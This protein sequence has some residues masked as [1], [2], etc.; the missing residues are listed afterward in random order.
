MAFTVFY[1]FRD[2]DRTR[3]DV[4][5]DVLGLGVEFPSGWCVVDWNRDAFPED[6]DN[7][8][9]ISGR[10]VL[11][12]VDDGG[13]LTPVTAEWPRSSKSQTAVSDKRRES[14]AKRRFP[15]AGRTEKTRSVAV[16]FRDMR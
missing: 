8:E 1:V 4:G 5:G 3:I 10:F 15:P 2:E 6:D 13:E 14:E 11:V 16:F 12:V 9:A 7:D